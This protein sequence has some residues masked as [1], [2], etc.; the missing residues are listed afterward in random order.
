MKAVWIPKFGK[1]DVLEVRESDDPAPGPGEVRIRARASGINFAYPTTDQGLRAL[2]T[3]PGEA[4]A[5]NWKPYLTSVPSDPWSNPY[6][7]RS[8]GQ[9][10]PDAEQPG[11]K[12]KPDGLGD[13]GQ[14]G[15]GRCGLPGPG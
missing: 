5:P 13:D 12:P 6:Q 1:P 9:Q 3:N 4:N 2:V 10:R 15:K 11:S 8:P 7:Y 14:S